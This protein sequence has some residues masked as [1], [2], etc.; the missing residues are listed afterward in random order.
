MYCQAP[1]SQKI[2]DVAVMSQKCASDEV[3]RKTFLTCGKAG[4]SDLNGDSSALSKRQAGF[5]DVQRSMRK[6]PGGEAE[7]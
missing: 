7:V 3:F 2:Q 5:S 1:R 6:G 4:A